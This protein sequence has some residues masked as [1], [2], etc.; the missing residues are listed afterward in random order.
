M[1]KLLLLL[2]MM[3]SVATFASPWDI[4][5]PKKQIKAFEGPILTDYTVEEQTSPHRI[6][7]FYKFNKTAT[8][9]QLM[10]IMVYGYWADIA[11]YEP[12]TF[13]IYIPPGTIQN[14]W[15]YNLASGDDLIPEFYDIYY[16]G[17]QP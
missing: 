3:I 10:T 15:Y 11:D 1:K 13:D 6:K 16:L 14:T 5:I 7:I 17:P 9:T 2:T 12:R 8:Y 4:G